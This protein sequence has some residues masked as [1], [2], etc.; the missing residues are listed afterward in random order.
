MG[1]LMEVFSIVSWL[2]TLPGILCDIILP[3]QCFPACYVM[4]PCWTYIDGHHMFIS[5]KML[6]NFVITLYKMMHVWLTR[7]HQM[8][9]NAL[10]WHFF[11]V[12]IFIKWKLSWIR[13]LFL[14]GRMRK[15]WKS[16]KPGGLSRFNRVRC[17]SSL[18]WTPV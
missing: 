5:S 18:K 4:V 17:L 11:D 16:A 10:I 2:M 6:R 9:Q 13:A 3:K 1:C 7:V 14:N 15:K 12:K 8:P